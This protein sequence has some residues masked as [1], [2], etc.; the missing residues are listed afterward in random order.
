MRDVALVPKRHVLKRGRDRGA[1]N[2][3]KSGQVFRQHRVALVGHGGRA[4]LTLGEELLRFHHF[5]AL[6]MPDLGR[7][8]L[9]RGGDVLLR[10]PLE[11]ARRR[12]DL[13][14]GNR[15]AIARDLDLIAVTDHD[16]V[17]VAD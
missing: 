3:R 9:G 16:H 11:L 12:R 4:L 17:E 6:Q 8:P 15:A 13:E 7:Q 2:T 10:L 1:H 5:G 14:A